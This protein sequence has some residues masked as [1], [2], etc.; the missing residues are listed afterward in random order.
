LLYEVLFTSVLGSCRVGGSGFYIAFFCIHLL[1][2]IPLL[3]LSI[4]CVLDGCYA[5]Q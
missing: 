2:F 4:L 1:C 3:W 5:M